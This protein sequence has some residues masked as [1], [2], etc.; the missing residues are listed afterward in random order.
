M[1]DL[2]AEAATLARATPGNFVL[3][4]FRR[5]LP[6]GVNVFEARDTLDNAYGDISDLQGDFDYVAAFD[7]TDKTSWPSP[8]QEF[9]GAIR[10]IAVKAAAPRVREGRAGWVAAGIAG[11]VGWIALR[12]R[13]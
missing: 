8:L 4:N 9:G 6:G 12:K 7:K 5:G 1:P 2:R 10:T 11:L 13:R 3:V